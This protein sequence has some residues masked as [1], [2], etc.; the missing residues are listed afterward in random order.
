MR[1]CAANACAEF[2]PWTQWP[3]SSWTS[4][5][6][7]SPGGG[8]AAL[9]S[10]VVARKISREW[11]VSAPSSYAAPD[12]VTFTRYEGVSMISVV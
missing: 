2:D 6:K 10:S 8:R 1:G 7:S 5:F 11:F 9:R 4:K 12:G 3:Y